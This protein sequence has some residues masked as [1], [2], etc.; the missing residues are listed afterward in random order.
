MDKGVI[1]F[2][3]P[4]I[5]VAQPRQRHRVISSG[6]RQFV[7]NYVATRDPVNAFKAAVQLAASQKRVK[8]IDGPVRL[9]LQFIF[10]RAKCRTWK[11]KPMVRCPKVTKPDVDNLAKSVMDALTH[12]LAWRDD[13][14]V[15]C[16]TVEKCEAAGGEQP[17]TVV[18]IMGILEVR[19]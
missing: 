12:G 3:V 17:H 5:P 13:C 2:V 8:C 4:G 9:H 19:Q 6:G 11:N 18:S 7:Q 15:C 1:T 14:Q 10:S 16:L